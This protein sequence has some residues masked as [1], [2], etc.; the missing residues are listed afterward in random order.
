MI[1]VIAFNVLMVLL[2]ASVATSVVPEKPLSSMLGYLHTTIGIS[3]P[4]SDKVRMVALIWIACMIIIVDGLLFLLV[5][6]TS[7][8]G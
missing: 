6:L 8:V 2:G 5:L 7:I 1:G 3:T 4:P